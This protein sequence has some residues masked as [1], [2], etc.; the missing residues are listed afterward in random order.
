MFLD[1]KK[2]FSWKFYSVKYDP[3]SINTDLKLL[4]VN[5]PAGTLHG[6]VV[7]Q[8]GVLLQPDELPH[9]VPRADTRHGVDGHPVAALR[10]H[11]RIVKPVY[12]KEIKRVIF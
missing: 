5:K 1:L 9:R 6:P 10:E 3:A 4:F 12:A 2:S 11:I 8:H 7:E